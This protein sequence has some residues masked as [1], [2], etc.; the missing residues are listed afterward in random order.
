VHSQH[1]QVPEIVAHRVPLSLLTFLKFFA[2]TLLRLPYPFIGDV[3]KGLGTTEASV[4]RMLAIGELSG[5]G[6]SFVGPQLDKGHHRRWAIR[7][8]LAAA[9]G[10]LIIGLV[11]GRAGLLIGFCLIAFGV[12]LVTTT[13][14]TFLG[15]STAFEQRGRVIGIFEVSWALS[16]LIGGVVAGWL[17]ETFTW[18]TP[19]FVFGLVLAISTPSLVRVMSSHTPRLIDTVKDEGNLQF[20]LVNCLFVVGVSVTLTLGQVLTFASFGTFL[21]QRHGFT[22][23]TLGG[24]VTALGIMELVGSVGIA[25][26]ADR[27]GKAN[28]VLLGGTVMGSGSV[29]FITLGMDSKPFAVAAVLVFFLGFEFAYVALLAIVS[30]VGGERRGTVV[31]V[32]HAV[33]NITR[34]AGAA[35]GPFLVGSTAQNF[36][37]V[38]LLV[39]GLIATALLL[40]FP[41]RSR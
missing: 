28:S 16:L 7:G 13:V 18:S 38:Q 26:V 40:I 33:V 11:G 6:G 19:F 15:D 41:M 17:I 1:Q 4:G 24:V 37:P 29:L 22:T 36:R 21:K 2:N 5:L 30:E 3:A 14:H 9:V 25:S 8:Y 31:S 23:L 32:D 39:L 12:N 20:N 10:G 27:L 35:L 34:A